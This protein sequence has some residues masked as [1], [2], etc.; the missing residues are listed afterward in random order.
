MSPVHCWFNHC[1]YSVI[2]QQTLY[3]SRTLWL[4]CHTHS[5][6][7]GFSANEHRAT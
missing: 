2:W 1:Y 4:A 7:A 3:R 5:C 6:R